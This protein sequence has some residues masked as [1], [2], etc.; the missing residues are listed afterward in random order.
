MFIPASPTT[1]DVGRYKILEVFALLNVLIGIRQ[2]MNVDRKVAKAIFGLG[3]LVSCKEVNVHG[4]READELIFKSRCYVA[5]ARQST[6]DGV[7]MPVT[8]SGNP[9]LNS[10]FALFAKHPADPETA[11]RLRPLD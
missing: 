4:I 1:S 2:D 9:Q 10:V 6:V 7:N 11:R 8:E 5:V 3:F